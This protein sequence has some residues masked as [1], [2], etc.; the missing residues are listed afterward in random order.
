MEERREVINQFIKASELIL[1]R[2][3]KMN[4]SVM[5]K[6]LHKI[7]ILIKKKTKLMGYDLRCF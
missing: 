3:S 2:N 5:E 7:A 6:E 1:G 4:N